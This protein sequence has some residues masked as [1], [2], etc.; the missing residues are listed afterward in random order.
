MDQKQGTMMA[1]FMLSE[2]DRHFSQQPLRRQTVGYRQ[3]ENQVMDPNFIQS[4]PGMKFYNDQ[5]QPI[6][7]DS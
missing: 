1:P 3:N 4:D 7:D 2:T 5:H 6:E